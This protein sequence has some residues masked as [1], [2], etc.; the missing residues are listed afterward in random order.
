MICF[1]V[2][3]ILK[4]LVGFH[5][6]FHD[7]YMSIRRSRAVDRK[8]ENVD[9][10][11]S[12]GPLS[13]KWK[14]DFGF[15]FNAIISSWNHYMY[16]CTPTYRAKIWLPR[17]KQFNFFLQL[18]CDFV[19]SVLLQDFDPRSGIS[20]IKYFI[21]LESLHSYRSWEISAMERKA[22]KVKVSSNQ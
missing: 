12:I 22:V 18:P 11:P 9:R 5:W 20:S 14:P 4:Y 7:I 10:F 3:F 17:L 6:A 16:V 8:A 19:N 2:K 21:R 1:L 13:L 15:D